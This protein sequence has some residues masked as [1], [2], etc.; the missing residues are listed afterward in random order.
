MKALILA[1]AL[2]SVST[3]ASANSQVATNQFCSGAAQ[4]AAQALANVNGTVSTIING[5]YSSNSRRFIVTLS[6][7]GTKRDR[8]I[9]DMLVVNKD[10]Q[11]DCIVRSV[12]V[13]GTPTRRN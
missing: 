9:V 2:A 10:S 12:N 7:M 5:S 11:H 13:S 1:L 6:D 3:S 8:Y 4:L